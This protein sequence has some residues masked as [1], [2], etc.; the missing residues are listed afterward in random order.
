M[1]T[2]E[3][4][5]LPLRKRIAPGILRR[6]RRV[7]LHVEPFLVVGEGDHLAN[8][9][10]SGVDYR[11]GFLS[12]ADIDELVRLEPKLPRD[13]LQ[14]W[15]RE[16]K[17]CFGVRDGPRVI[18]KMWC[19]TQA[20]NFPPN[21]RTLA[22][23][24]VYLYAAHVDPAYRGHNLAPMMRA[25]CCDALKK[26]G[27]TRFLSYTDYYNYP[28]RRFKAKLGARDELLRL[29]VKLFGRWSK[30]FTLKRY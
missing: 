20:F 16:G 27:R 5:K 28:A 3:P 26:M 11:F 4:P 12:E 23:D 2:H 7:G 21:F 13:R 18:A 24:E 22:A 6:L 29:H 15:F 14:Q 19:D 17:L 30:T 25:A 10:F 8:Q 1:N 9:D